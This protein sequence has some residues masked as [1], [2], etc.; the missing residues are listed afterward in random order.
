VGWLGDDPAASEHAG[1]MVSSRSLC[2]QL[3]LVDGWPPRPVQNETR[4]EEGEGA[5]NG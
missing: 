5:A 1:Q 4:S 2:K 3:G